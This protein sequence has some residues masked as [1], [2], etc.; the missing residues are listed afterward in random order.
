MPS[1]PL[2][3]RPSSSPASPARWPSRWP[4]PWPR[5][6]EVVAGARFR[7]AAARE[8]LE[9]AGVRC[10]PIDL[11][12][13]DVARPPGRRRLR[14]QLRRVQDQRLGAATSGPTAAGWPA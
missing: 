6:N 1:E 9:A 13:G 10:V 8:R 4:W 2:R 3:A 11:L 12:T 7:D 14:R 5:D